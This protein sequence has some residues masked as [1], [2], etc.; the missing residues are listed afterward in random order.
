MNKP[1]NIFASV[2]TA[3]PGHRWKV[4]LTTCMREQIVGARTFLSHREKG[5]GPA[6]PRVFRYS[7]P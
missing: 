6:L 4:F 2:G 5:S 1:I 7:H 3:T